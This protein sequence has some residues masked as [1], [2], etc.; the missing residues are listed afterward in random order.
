MYNEPMPTC[1]T[2][3]YLG[4]T[5]DI[6][7][8][9]WDLHIERMVEKTDKVLY[10]FKSNG[11]NGEGFRERTKLTIMEA[12]IRSTFEYCCNHAKGAKVDRYT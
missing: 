1:N 11:F 2:F 8:I 12:F 5:F 3:K 7:G 10:F 9:R 4:C 6:K